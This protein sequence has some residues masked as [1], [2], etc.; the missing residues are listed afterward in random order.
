MCSPRCQVTY[1]RPLSAQ[2]KAAGESN[3]H[4]AYRLSVH[5]PDLRLSNQ[6]DGD[7]VVAQGEGKRQ[8]ICVTLARRCSAGGASGY[9]WLPA[10]LALP[11]FARPWR[12]KVGVHM[13]E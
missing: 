6:I 12:N 1:V 3:V 5:L 8:V 11:L 4:R 2:R 13:Y 9:C 7:T 10:W